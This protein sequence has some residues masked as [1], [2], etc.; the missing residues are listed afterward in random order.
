[1]RMYIVLWWIFYARALTKWEWCTK[2]MDKSAAFNWKFDSRLYILQKVVVKYKILLSLVLAFLSYFEEFQMIH[3]C[4][5][6]PF[7][8]KFPLASLEIFLI[9]FQYEYFIPS[10]KVLYLTNTYKANSIT[11]GPI[12]LNVSLF[13]YILCTF[14]SHFNDVGYNIWPIRWQIMNFLIFNDIVWIK[15]LHFKLP[16]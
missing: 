15:L 6:I 13:L 11:H 9:L 16:F 1:M 14:I 12:Y 2:T 5:W 3:K 8:N 4:N 7:Y 10:F